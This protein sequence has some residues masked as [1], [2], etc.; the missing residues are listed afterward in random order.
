[1]SNEPIKITYYPSNRWIYR[2]LSLEIV[3]WMDGVLVLP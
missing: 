2:E 3:P 1:V